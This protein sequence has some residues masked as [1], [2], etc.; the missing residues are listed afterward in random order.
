MITT[1][2]TDKSK[3]TPPATQEARWFAIYT[4]YKSEKLVAKTLEEKGIEAYTPI[5]TKV[6]RY[7][8]K[9]KRV[10]LPLISCYAFVKITADRSLEVL[11]TDNVLHFVKFAG[12]MIP[13][14]EA[15]IALLKRITGENVPVEAYAGTSFFQKGDWVEIESGNLAGVKGQ[16]I[17]I[18]N[19]KKLLVQ[20]E[21]VG[22][23]LQVEVNPALLRKIEAQSW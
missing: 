9:I 4:R 18:E 20:L 19:K 14:P 2:S 8:R 7:T 10:E 13:I 21:S 16:L 12:E 3:E 1:K 22:Y 5:Q 15:E 6:R 11:Q 23:S 17:Q